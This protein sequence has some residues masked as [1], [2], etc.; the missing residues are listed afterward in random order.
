MAEGPLLELRGITKSFGPVEV[1]H[2]VDLDVHRGEVHAVLGENGAGKSTLMNILAG[3]YGDYGGT[4][5]LDGEEVRFS[6]P[7]EAQQHG[8]VMIHQER[9]VVEQLS[10]AENIRLGQLPGRAGVVRWRGVREQAEAALA[11]IG[12]KLDP[13]R[14]VS[15]LNAGEVKLV[16]IARA[17]QRRPQ[18]LIMDEPTAALTPGEIDALFEVVRRFKEAGGTVV[19]ISHHLAEV[20][21]IAGRVTVLRDGALVLTSPVGET[22]AEKLVNSMVGR[23]LEL[24]ERIVEDTPETTVLLEVEGLETPTG[25][26]NVSLEVHEGEIVA[27]AGLVGS[28]RTETALAIFGADP[29]R[30]RMLLSGRPYAPRSPA[31]AIAAGVV[32]LSEDRA[33]TG[34]L[35][36]ATVADNLSLTRLRQTRRGLGVDTS[37]LNTLAQELIDRLRVVPPQARRVVGQLS[38]GNQQKVALGKSLIENAKLLMLDEP[39]RGVDVGA[40]ADIHRVIA[41]QAT[42][43]RAVLLISSDVP[44]IRALAHR[45]IVLRRGEVAAELSG[46]EATEEAMLAAATIGKVQ[47]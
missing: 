14:K 23:A 18:V 31:D 6:G 25:V 13:N 4:Y 40:K 38:G 9:Q 7:R 3:V 43:G 11:E 32:Y 10:V 33:S 29:W 26:K 12:V 27:L 34:L 37:R 36:E 22:S 21:R 39:T 15:D 24:H 35:L 41:N 30:G 1:L 19:Y 46:E 42:E 20:F 17:L 2:G 28:R 45:V 8:V 16:E 44:E 5:R 47:G